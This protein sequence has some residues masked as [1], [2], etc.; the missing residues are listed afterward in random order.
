MFESAC[1][2]AFLPFT[3]HCLINVYRSHGLSTRSRPPLP[4]V[5]RSDDVEYLLGDSIGDRDATMGCGS[6]RDICACRHNCPSCPRERSQRLSETPHPS[7]A[8]CVP[9]PLRY[10]IATETKYKSA[11]T[12]LATGTTLYMAQAV[13][14]LQFAKVILYMCF[15]ACRTLEIC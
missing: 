8:L 3:G 7:H 9:F 4:Y 15:T 11:G 5:C 14:T 6:G 13:C 12:S 10:A 2:H 1:K